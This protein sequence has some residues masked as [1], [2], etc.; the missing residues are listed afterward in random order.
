VCVVCVCVCVHVRMRA[1]CVNARGE[2]YTYSLRTYEL[3][4]LVEG[5]KQ[6]HKE[7]DD[8]SQVKRDG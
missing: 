1:C 4:A 2:L 6:S 5:I 8:H 3:G 7:V